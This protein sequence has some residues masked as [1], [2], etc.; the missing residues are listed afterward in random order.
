M[1]LYTRVLGGIHGLRDK[2]GT[3]LPLMQ[4]IRVLGHSN[5]IL[6]L[7]SLP[8]RQSILRHEGTPYVSY[9]VS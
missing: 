2:T 1:M 9:Y 7:K 3:P 5:V 6:S 8:A 4:K